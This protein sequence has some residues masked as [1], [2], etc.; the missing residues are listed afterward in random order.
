MVQQQ[1]GTIA[2]DLL[3]RNLVSRGT[4]ADYQIAAHGR[5][6]LDEGL[7]GVLAADAGL[8]VRNHQRQESFQNLPITPP[9]HLHR[10]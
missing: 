5:L 8:E 4:H 9:P 6:L 7:D 1:N 3:R 10:T 2:V